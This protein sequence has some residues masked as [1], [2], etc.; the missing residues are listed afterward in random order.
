MVKNWDSFIAGA[1]AEDGEIYCR[2]REL[3]HLLTVRSKKSQ[4]FDFVS[5]SVA[6]QPRLEHPAAKGWLPIR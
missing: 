2:I 4:V 5:L 3:L 1:A 6:D